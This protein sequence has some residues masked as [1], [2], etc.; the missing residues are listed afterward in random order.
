MNT[1]PE[2]NEAKYAWLQILFTKLKDQSLSFFLIAIIAWYFKVQIDELK[3]ERNECDN[4]TK[5]VLFKAIQ[6][7]TI[8]INR[9]NE[10]DEEIKDL[11]QEMRLEMKER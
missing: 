4:Y 11:I 7:N 1:I 10:M 6:A 2:I 3:K 5:T 9:S 8:V